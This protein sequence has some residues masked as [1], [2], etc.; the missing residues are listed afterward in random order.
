MPAQTSN[1]SNLVTIISS[2]V[3]VHQAQLC[4]I[5][6]VLC[7]HCEP[8]YAACVREYRKRITLCENSGSTP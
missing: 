4:S 1:A 3:K 5:L 7:T 6:G 8:D 2:S